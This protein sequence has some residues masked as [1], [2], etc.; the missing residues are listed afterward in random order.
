LNDETTRVA[1]LNAGQGLAMAA[2]GTLAVILLAMGMEVLSGRSLSLLVANVVAA[3]I[4]TGIAL[5]ARAGKAGTQGLVNGLG[6][7]LGQLLAVLSW[8]AY[9]L[10]PDTIYFVMMLVQL[11]AAGVLFMSTR[12]LLGFIGVNSVATL[13]VVHFGGHEQDGLLVIATAFLALTVHFV[14]RKRHDA[15]AEHHALR[16]RR[17]L[18]QANLR[19][20]EKERA[21][22]EREAALRTSAAFEE[23]LRQSQKME[24]VG[25]LA[26]GLAHDMNNMLTAIM[27][28]A[29]V[30][31]VDTTS[32]T[33]REDA[34]QILINAR[35]ASDLTRNL[36]TVSRR[37]PH[38]RQV[39]HPESTVTA[40]VA[41][42]SRTLPRSVRVET[43][44]ES[45]LTSFDGDEGQVIHA[46]L[47]LGLNAADAMSQDGV[48]TIGVRMTELSGEQAPPGLS[49]GR[50]VVI[51]V[52]DTG[53]GMDSET[54]KRIF[55]PFF[56]TKP[57]GQ[58]TGLGLSMVYGTMQ[59]HG[60]AV[61]VSSQMDKGSTFELIFPAGSAREESPPS[62]KAPRHSGSVFQ[63]SVLVI[64]DE[65]GVRL[66]VSRTL[67]RAGYLVGL[68][69]NGEEALRTL[70]HTT[71][72]LVLLDMTMPIMAGPETFRR[73]R[74]AHPGLRVLLM[75]GYTNPGEASALISE[76]AAGLLEKP[77][78]K[79]NL[80]QAVGRARPTD[81]PDNVGKTASS[82]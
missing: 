24:A 47:N 4:A 54:Q 26:G 22:R 33:V 70:D 68:A 2:W 80:L 64:E 18:D 57:V 3:A 82:A 8:L 6:A 77:F 46:V 32:V 37:H 28:L 21:E 78:P 40:I 79:A 50:Y 27:G 59:R 72:D 23:Q 35:R 41:L 75:S 17:A 71:F 20:E 12:W 69:P 38:N 45:D 81:R 53:A 10:R 29:E 39:L 7:A 73:A 51:F 9:F 1:R 13:V 31:A 67:E 65:P 30:I 74:A 58:G 52:K 76:G 66:L 25:T 42:L 56:T 34:E 43:S 44:F 15:E 49:P 5:A 36:L 48:L 62:R 60:G 14:L 11:V 16:L 55:E 19:L 61:L 63:K